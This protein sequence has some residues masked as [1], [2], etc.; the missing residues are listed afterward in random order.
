MSCQQNTVAF[1]QSDWT[2]CGCG[3]VRGYY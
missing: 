2:E 1:K 3:T